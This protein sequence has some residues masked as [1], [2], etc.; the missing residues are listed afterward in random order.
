MH[1]EIKQEV[2]SRNHVLC[3]E[4]CLS[5]IYHSFGKKKKECRKLKSSYCDLK[6]CAKY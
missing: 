5:E 2:T 3:E 6:L 4:E 1:S